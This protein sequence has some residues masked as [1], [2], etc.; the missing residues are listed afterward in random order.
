MITK[1]PYSL[2]VLLASL[3]CLTASSVRAIDIEDF[4]TDQSVT[5]T[6]AGT[7]QSSVISNPGSLGLYRTFTASV[8]A[9]VQVGGSTF[10]GLYGHQAFFLS[11]GKTTITWDCNSDAS[12]TNFSSCPALD[13]LSDGADSI[14]L[15][16]VN[17]DW[18]N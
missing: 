6:G 17:Y 1:N 13:L 14:L 16:R 18:S 7:T 3:I 4:S 15:T 12:T 9:G 2:F 8:T 10:L 5:A 11:S